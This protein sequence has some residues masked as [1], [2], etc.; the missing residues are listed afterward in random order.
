MFIRLRFSQALF[1]VIV[2][3]NEKLRLFK[4]WSKIDA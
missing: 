2:N 4:R 3:C 1:Q